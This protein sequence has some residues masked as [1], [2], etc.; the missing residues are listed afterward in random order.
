[1]DAAGVTRALPIDATL[2][3]NVL[4]HLRRDV[5]ATHTCWTLGDRGSIE[6]DV[7]F[8]PV[9]V[10]SQAGP[11]WTSSARLYDPAHVAV[12]LAT[13]EIVVRS[14]ESADLVLRPRGDLDPWW[15]A[16][17]PALFALASAAID[18][19]AEE[20]LWH[21]TREGVAQV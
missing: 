5:A 16:R 10:S 9:M 21:A 1:M 13:V 12:T 15:S 7:H 6:L 18:E 4:L 19:L 2:V 3:N 8:M 17:K 11:T 20:M 14:A